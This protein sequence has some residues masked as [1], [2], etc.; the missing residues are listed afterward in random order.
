MIT[1]IEQLEN[2]ISRTEHQLLMHLL[3]EQKETNRL[4][5]LLTDKP[6]ETIKSE[7]KPRV[8]PQP[9]PRGAKK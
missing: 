5:R 2:Q 3:I 9:K 6:Q 1:P 7:P 8:K 4:L